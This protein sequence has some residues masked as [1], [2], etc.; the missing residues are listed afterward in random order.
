LQTDDLGTPILTQK[1]TFQCWDHG[2]DGRKFSSLSNYR[3][4]CRERNATSEALICCPYCGQNFTRTSGRDAHIE[5]GRCYKANWS[6]IDVS[7]IGISDKHTALPQSVPD[8]NDQHHPSSS[9]GR[10]A[11]NLWLDNYWPDLGHCNSW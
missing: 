6:T 2:C 10:V 3:R 8:N 11:S 7:T 4:H 5:R 1:T 9:H